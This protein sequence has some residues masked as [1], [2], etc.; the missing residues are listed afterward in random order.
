MKKYKWFLIIAA[1]CLA[2]VISWY[3][4][5]DRKEK[6]L[7]LETEKPHVGFI[8][9][10]ITATGTIQPVDTVSV[11]TQVSGTIKYIYADFNSKVKK[12]QLLAE[13][14]KSLF[15][16]LVDQMKANLSSAK[17]Q[18]VYQ[19]SNFSRQSQLYNVGAISKADYETAMY[20]YTSAKANLASISAQLQS[21]EKN[22]SY[23]DIYS[24]I[25][26]TVLSR[27]VSTGQ[28]V[29]ASFNTPTLF[30]IAKDLTKM[31][32]QADVDEADIGNVEKGEEVTFTVDAFPDDNFK[33]TVQDVRLNP[34]VSANVVTYTT[35]VDAPNENMKLKP[36]M[37]ASI[38]IYTKQAENAM[39]I[40]AKALKY[41]PDS[42]LLKQFKIVGLSKPGSKHNQ[43]LNASASSMTAHY[44]ADSTSTDSLQSEDVK[45]AFVWIKQNDT[46]MKRHIKIGLNDDTH[47]QVVQGLNANDV[48][49]DDE[50]QAGKKQTTSDNTVKSPFMPQRPG[51]NNQR[52]N[53]S[54]S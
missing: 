9:N 45:N 1:I 48:V 14:D 22:L 51:S 17:D 7:T 34:T 21:A 35:I 42:S 4:K 44:N 20:G 39:L 40:S 47:V 31:Q 28:T 15:Q 33:G 30:V 23:A 54:K 27:N 10:S 53:Q 49:I 11:G 52:P 18:L 5:F 41:K 46:I 2:G 16:A 19:Q 50:Q 32:V 3:W 24:P 13:L 36:G 38:T 43:Q 8:A 12:G 37:T 29:A 6:P 26:C 25:D